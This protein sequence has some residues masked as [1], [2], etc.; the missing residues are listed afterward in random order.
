MSERAAWLSTALEAGRAEWPRFDVHADE[1]S[2]VL[3]ARL[4]TDASAASMPELRVELADL[5]ARELYLAAACAKGHAVALAALR[6]RYFAPVVPTLARMGLGTA[7]IDDV[8]QQLCERLV[9]KGADGAP[10][11]ITRYAGAG[12]LGG[13]VRVAATR[14]AMSWI[15]HEQRY[16]SDEVLAGFAAGAA[17]PE[18]QVMKQQHREDLKEELA[19][20]VA[21][22]SVHERTVLRLHLVQHVGIEGLATA[23][24]VHRSTAV[25][26]ISGAKQALVARVRDRLATRWR[27][28]DVSL[29]ALG[30][31]VDSQVDLSLG[32]LLGGDQ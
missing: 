26:W 25:R 29:G 6:Q 15:E 24:G 9:V 16:G 10:A 22:L 30:S 32:R 27:I 3:T 18:L 1:L 11:K 4:G 21:S 23:Y 13:L 19:G 7:Q 20:A 17:G 12:E 2:A 8:W 14:L 28:S 5:D 31:L